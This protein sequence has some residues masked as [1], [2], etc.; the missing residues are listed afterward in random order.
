LTFTSVQFL[1]FTSATLVLYRF[2]PLR[3]RAALL[4]VAS[5]LFYW[6]W[7]PLAA[8]GM[9]A[10]TLLA[11]LAGKSVQG[12]DSPHR[13][14]ITATVV[15]CLLTAYLA[16]FKIA[17]VLPRFGR[18]ALPLGLSYYTFKLMSYVMDIYWGKIERQRDLFAFAAYVA[19]FP[20]IVAGPIQRPGQFMDQLPP[21]KT[22]ISMGVPRIAWGLAKKVLIAGN[23]AAA[24]AYVFGNAGSLHTVEALAALYLFPLY[25]YVD[26]SALT[27]IAI[28]VAL[29]FGIESPENFNR[30]FTASSISDYWRRWHMSLTTWLA[31]Y[32]FTPLRMATRSAGKAGLAFSITVN[33]VAIGLW[34]GVAWGYLVFGL[35]HAAALIADSFTVRWRTRL[36]NANPRL[37]AWGKLF[38]VLITFHVVGVALVFF[39]APSVMEALALLRHIFLFSGSV[40]AELAHLFA[41]AGARAFLAGLVGLAVMELVERYRPD[42]WW[43]RLEVALPWWLRR[44]AAT[45][46][47]VLMLAGI[48]ILLVRA[49]REAT[50]FLYQIF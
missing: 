45:T 39:R 30:P 23:L 3:F 25:M 37:D 42:R 20:Q 32:V 50:P 1:V 19:F 29:L 6:T 7:S 33:M 11:F 10:A 28:G 38:G 17:A 31:D 14:K 46:G 8:A 15:I 41:M 4:L 16:F 5:Y 35:I 34:H 43:A 13:A 49:E 22:A 24:I 21:K 18:L 9:A 48:F 36:F 47:T 27:D 12:E 44:L 40:N 2:C 26:F